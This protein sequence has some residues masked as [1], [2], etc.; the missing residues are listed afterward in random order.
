[1][2][3]C[4]NKFTWC[5]HK[6]IFSF[7]IHH[8][9]IQTYTAKN[10]ELLKTA[11]NNVVLPTLF[12]LS[13]ILFSIVTPDGRLDSGSTICSVLLTTLNNVRSTT[14]FNPVFNNIQQLVIFT[15]VQ[16]T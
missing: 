5:F 1:M 15:R 3:L 14:L 11:L 16:G 7:D 10:Y 2:K 13:T 6:I 8:A 12:K 4:D 9:N